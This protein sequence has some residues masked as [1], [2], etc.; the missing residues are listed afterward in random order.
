MDHGP[1]SEVAEVAEVAEVVE[2]FS[3]CCRGCNPDIFVL[4]PQIC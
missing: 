1:W 3:V 4:E 2:V